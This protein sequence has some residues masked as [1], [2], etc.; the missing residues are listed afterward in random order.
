M[1]LSTYLPTFVI[2]H[3]AIHDPSIYPSTLLSVSIYISIMYHLSILLISFLWKI[4]TGPLRRGRQH[5]R[6][7]TGRIPVSS[8]SFLSRCRRLV[9][10]H[11]GPQSGRVHSISPFIFSCSLLSIL[12][13]RHHVF[14]FPLRVCLLSSLTLHRQSCSFH[15]FDAR[16]H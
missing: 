6:A 8:I 4:L 16:V 11:P 12:P 3:P 10:S 13:G 5:C 1:D 15:Y 9:N 14:L 2:Y 7:L